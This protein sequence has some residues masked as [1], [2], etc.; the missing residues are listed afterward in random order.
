MGKRK[1]WG[2]LL[3]DWCLLIC[4]SRLFPIVRGDD[5]GDD[6]AGDVDAVED[7]E[8]HKQQGGGIGGILSMFAGLPRHSSV[9]LKAG[10]QHSHVIFSIRNINHFYNICFG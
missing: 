7:A 8:I 5:V 3:D 1:C 6:G 9:A 10:V 2:G 4:I